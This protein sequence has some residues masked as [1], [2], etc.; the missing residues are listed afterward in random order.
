MTLAADRPAAPTITHH[1]RLFIDGRFVDAASGETFESLNP[2]TNEPFARVAKAGREDVEA[3]VRAARRAFDEG[4]WPRM[5]PAERKKIL[6]RIADGIEA[7]ADELARLESIDMGKP[8]TEAREKDVPRAALNFRF[9]ADYAALSHTEMFEQ[10]AIGVLTYTLREPRGVALL[11]TPWNFPLMLETWKVAP[12][13]AFGNTAILKP[14]SASPATANVLLEICAE[15]GLPEGV[16]NLVYGDGETVGMALV[17]HPGV[18]L[19]SLTGES[20]TGKRIAAAAAKTLKKCSFELGGKSASIVFADADLDVALPGSLDAIFRNQG[21][22]CLAGSRLLVQR[23]IYD[24]FV[25]RYVD[26]ARAYRVGD[27]LDPATQ[28]GPLVSPGHWERVRRYVGIGVAEGGTLLTGGDRPAGPA[29]ERGNF[30]APTV[31]GDVRPE[32]RV[33]QEEIFGPVQ[34]V[35]PFDTVEDAIRLANDSRYGL[36]GMVWTTN[37]ETAHRVAAGVRTGTMWVNC[38]FV[39]DLRVPFGGFRESGTGRE[40]GKWSEDFFTESKSVVLKLRA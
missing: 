8:I 40:G 15:A 1:F 16:L 14:A 29:F 27:P 26:G 39:R 24:E 23:S 11:I 25:A 38:F 19:I 20:S 34:V 21:E 18:D 35:T 4:P 3:A 36:A 28:I 7:R 22:V 32:H 10:R 2:T 5:S 37:L 30:F 33:F 12:A 17:E 13:L 31:I 9:F 6:Y